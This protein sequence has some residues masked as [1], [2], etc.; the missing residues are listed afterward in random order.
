MGYDG[1]I[2]VPDNFLYP[3]YGSRRYSTLFEEVAKKKNFKL[4]KT[5]YF[6]KEEQEGDICIVFC[7]LQHSYIYGNARSLD[8]PEKI[9]IIFYPT[10]LQHIDEPT[11][12]EYRAMYERMLSR[13]VKI[14][15]PYKEAFIE[16]WGSKPEYMKKF[17]W[18]PHSF[19]YRSIWEKYSS[20]NRFKNNKCL[21]PGYAGL[22]YLMRRELLKY[23][24]LSDS[25]YHDEKYVGNII[26][27]RRPMFGEDYVKKLNSYVCCF[28]CPSRFNY[29]L[30][31]YF[32]I[33]A[34]GSLLVAK[35][36][37]DIEEL[38]FIPNVHYIEVQEDNHI[39]VIRAILKGENKYDDIVEEGRKLVL[40]NFGIEKRIKQLERIIDEVKKM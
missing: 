32:E 16:W 39:D 8:M 31:K 9:K 22:D 10:D 24:E 25:I 35:K 34:A 3:A 28:T 23:P 4:L 36:C 37:K 20:K 5:L 38:G 17:E 26:V 27:N 18:F 11:I 33:P 6:R 21:N 15:C 19:G 2:L 40:E 30:A 1:T 29:P 12:P 14:I 7:G 13:A